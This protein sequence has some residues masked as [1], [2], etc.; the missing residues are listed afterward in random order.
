MQTPQNAHESHILSQNP[1]SHLLLLLLPPS[2]FF[3][4]NIL[5]RPRPRRIRRECIKPNA[6]AIIRRHEARDVRIHLPGPELARRVQR[7]AQEAPRA[8]AREAEVS[9][10]QARRVGETLGHSTGG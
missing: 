2:I 7:A 6:R 3:P 4:S 10:G 8:Q 1:T 5:K 9:K